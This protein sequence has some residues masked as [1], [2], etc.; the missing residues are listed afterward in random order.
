MWHRT[1]TGPWS[2]RRLPEMAKRAISLR[3]LQKGLGIGL[4]G[5]TGRT[6]ISNVIILGANALTGVVSARAL[7]PSGRGEL[8][9]ALLW[10]AFI[11]TAGSLGL[12]SACS[13]YVARWPGRRAA[14]IAWLTRV[15]AWQAAGM[16]A[17]SAAVLWWLHVHLHLP[18]LLA[19]EFTIWP[20]VSTALLYGACYAQGLGDFGRFNAI[21]ALPGAVTAVLM[22]SEAALLHLTAAEAGATYVFPAL[23]GAI[24]GYRWL[25]QACGGGSGDP[26]SALERRA[27]WSYG[28]RS[29]ASF[30]GLTLNLSGDQLAL[31]LLLPTRALGLYSVGSSAST[32]LASVV[33]SYGLVG[34]PT[35]ARLTGDQKDRV[36][37]QKLRRATFL[38]VL[39]APALAIALPWAIPFVYGPSYRAAVV[40]GELLLL[41][42]VFAALTAVTDNLL[43]AHDIPGFVSVGQGCGAAVTIIG[44]VLVAHRS[45]AAVALLSTVGFAV[46]CALSLL[47]LR[48]AASPRAT[49]HPIRRPT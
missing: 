38:A 25:R 43:R 14:F 6:T 35:V 8:T 33:G 21:R 10:T 39:M 41:G 16:L 49:R 31:G 2:R 12:S 32:P 23:A 24:V 27:A 22:S 44:A 28:L 18:A 45:L 30:S 42:A 13:Y 37:W 46:A 15:S 1:P 20:V 3:R 47:R 11:Q 5:S 9:L 48:M 34:L 4:N 36:P 17:V 19:A 7:G 29:L 26:L 40:P